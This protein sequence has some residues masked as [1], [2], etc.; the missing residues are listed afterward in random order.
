MQMKIFKKSDKLRQ[1][2]TFFLSANKKLKIVDI[3]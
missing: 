1:R 2:E 3:I